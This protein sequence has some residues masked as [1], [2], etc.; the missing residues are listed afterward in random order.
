MGIAVPH[1]SVTL[2]WILQINLVFLKEAPNI[3]K[4]FQRTEY[5]D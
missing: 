5:G 2:R 4:H 1:V 3:L